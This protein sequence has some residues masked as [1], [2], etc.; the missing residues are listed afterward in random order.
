MPCLVPRIEI[1]TFIREAVF[2]FFFAVPGFY[3]LFCSKKSLSFISI[4]YKDSA[5]RMNTNII[6]RSL[7]S[8]SICM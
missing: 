3:C 5:I 8:Y 2:P 6:L 1:L 7:K 4:K